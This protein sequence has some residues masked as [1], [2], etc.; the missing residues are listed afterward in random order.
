MLSAKTYW[1]KKRKATTKLFHSTKN[2]HCYKLCHLHLRYIGQ[3]YYF[4]RN[5]SVIAFIEELQWSS[6]KKMETFFPLFCLFLYSTHSQYV[7]SKLDF[8]LWQFMGGIKPFFLPSFH[9]QTVELKWYLFCPA[10]QQV[11]E[12][13]RSQ[14]KESYLFPRIC[15]FKF[16]WMEMKQQ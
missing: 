14:H 4:C 1:K 12:P 3:L 15:L 5:L 8:I 10:F 6:L 13:W 9:L 16:S 7:F 2:N 11:L